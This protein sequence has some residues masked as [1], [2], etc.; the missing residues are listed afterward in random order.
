MKQETILNPNIKNQS[1]YDHL[2]IKANHF[3]QKQI[4]FINN[5]F[6]S[7]VTLKSQKRLR[8]KS[9]R[10]FSVGKGELVHLKKSPDYCE[11]DLEK[12]ILG[13]SGRVCNK[14]SEG[15]DRCSVLCCGRGFNTKV[16]FY[17]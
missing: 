8:R 5:Y 2:A 15:P 4:F 13:T 10:K 16:R 14:T 7:Q 12:G 1:K 6:C 9:G 3:R 17:G 11:Y